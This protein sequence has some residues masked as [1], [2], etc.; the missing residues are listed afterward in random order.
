MSAFGILERQLLPAP[1]TLLTVFSLTDYISRIGRAR[2]GIRVMGN[3][4]PRPGELLRSLKKHAG[5][6]GTRDPWAIV[7]ELMDMDEPYKITRVRILEDLNF[8]RRMGVRFMHLGLP[9]S[10]WRHGRPIM[11]STWLLGNEQGIA[12]RV[13]HALDPIVSRLDVQVVATPWPY[14]ERQHVDHRIVSECATHIAERRS[15]RL[16]YLD[17]LPY[18][19]R[20]LGV[21]SNTSGNLYVPIT[22]RLS[23]EEMKAKLAAMGLYWSQ[24]IPEYRQA[25][26][27]PAPESA[28]RGYTETLW[29]PAS[30]ENQARQR[31]VTP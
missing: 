13:C 15:L 9:D 20:P 27:N 5:R 18:S 17:D 6:F 22:V 29:Q 26:L 25:V 23:A 8:S 24:M 4:L 21:M 10:K 19:R 11:D 16:L 30:A 2:P 7:T 3:L 12:D 1:I 28:E 14:G 31:G